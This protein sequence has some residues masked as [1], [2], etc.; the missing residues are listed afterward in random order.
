MRMLFVWSAE[1]SFEA[2][3]NKTLPLPLPARDAGQ[4]SWKT[5]MDVITLDDVCTLQLAQYVQR[6]P[7]CE[8]STTVCFC[9]CVCVCVC[10]YLC[11]WKPNAF[12]H[13]FAALSLSLS[14]SLPDSPCVFFYVFLTPPL[15]LFG[16]L[17]AHFIARHF[18]YLLLHIQKILRGNRA[19]DH[20]PVALSVVGPLT[21]LDLGS[22]MD[23]PKT[24]FRRRHF[25]VFGADL[26]TSSS[27]SH[28]LILSSNC[29]F[30]TIV[31]LVVMF[32]T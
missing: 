4:G 21:F 26:K 3:K 18:F 25:Q 17:G 20:P 22:G 19:A 31:V 1:G 30:D 10:V 9:V 14:L 28:I 27:S 8:H 32:I 15:G 6:L 16:G 5:A 24:L 7:G 2:R 23:C 12:I 11:L 13:S 29:T